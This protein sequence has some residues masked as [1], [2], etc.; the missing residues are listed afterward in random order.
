[1]QLTRDGDELLLQVDGLRRTIVL[2]RA[3]V[4]APT[5]GAKMDEGILRIRFGTRGDD[6]P[7]KA[8]KRVKLA[9]G[10]KR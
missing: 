5:T 1:V 4:D 6:A 9:A 8:T 10:G 7:G 3:L 2:P